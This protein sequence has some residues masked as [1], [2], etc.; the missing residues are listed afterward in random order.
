MGT[1]LGSPPWLPPQAGVGPCLPR[2]REIRLVSCT[3]LLGLF[4]FVLP[5]CRAHGDQCGFAVSIIPQSSGII[6]VDTA[7]SFAGTGPVH[8][9]TEQNK[10]RRRGQDQPQDGAGSSYSPVPNS[11]GV[12][13]VPVGKGKIRAGFLVVTGDPAL[14]PE[15]GI[16]Q[17]S[18]PA[19]FP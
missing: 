12:G 7:F 3:L 9:V 2:L 6:P 15:P 4:C 11:C 10:F 5:H 19:C 1:R 8:A 14:V 17:Q 18:F 16:S 13:V